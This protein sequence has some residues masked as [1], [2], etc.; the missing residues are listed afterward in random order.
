MNELIQNGK[1]SY[2]L[3]DIGANIGLYSRQS[4][5][6]FKKI[7]KVFAYE[8]HPNNY[9]LLQKNLE[10]IKNVE[11][12][13]FGL[14]SVSGN[15]KFY[16]DPANNGNYSLNK[17]AMSEI[18][19]QINVDIKDALEESRKWINSSDDDFIYKSDTQGHDETIVSAIDPSFWPRVKCGV[20]ELWR[21]GG[22][23]YDMDSFVRML[24]SFPCKMFE[25]NPGKNVTSSEILQFLNSSDGI[26]ED[27]LFWRV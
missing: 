27:L 14:S 17:N 9:F 19:E 21:I 4:I 22:K 13:M 11:I 24:D 18:H 3:I 12:N 1:N 5:N 15:L 25:K 8:P 7:D 20:L 10:N 26:S 2:T 16:L 23:D 6:I